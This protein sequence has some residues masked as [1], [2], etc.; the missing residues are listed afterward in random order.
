MTSLWVEWIGATSLQI[1]VLVPV[2]YAIDR[3]IDRRTWPGLQTA[4]WAVVLGRLVFPPS[5][6]WLPTATDAAMLGL[7]SAL[8]SRASREPGGP[9]AMLIS[10]WAI[11]VVLLTILAMT[12]HY[13]TRRRLLQRP[14]RPMPP[15]V[16]ELVMRLVRAIPSRSVPPV[17]VRD[18]VR[19]P[20][21]VGVLRPV[22]VLPSFMLDRRV[23]LEHAVLHEL[24]HVKRRDPLVNAL[25]LGLHL[26]YWF[27]PM[28]WF[29]RR[30]LATLREVACDA[31]AVSAS[32]TQDGYRT[33][34]LRLARELVTEPRQPVL[35][36]FG[37]AGQLLT[38][39][40]VLERPIRRASGL[41]RAISVAL[42]A[43]LLATCAVLARPVA[44]AADPDAIGPMGCLR[45]RYAVYAELAAEMKRESSR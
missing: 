14:V 20:C 2:I 18:D 39:L 19:G 17:I 43:M 3:L 31:R 28:V 1:V 4:L 23:E 21:V 5:T 34:L 29:A 16:E 10:V 35:G 6:W 25:C 30:R 13:R 44:A 41:Q 22:V 38:R 42:C 7:P 26:V 40:A 8:V 32:G 37:S 24:A 11:G 9:A 33:T 45:W 27:H 36:L 12:R 15:D